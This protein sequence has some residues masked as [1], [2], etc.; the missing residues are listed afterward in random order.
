MFIYTIERNDV[1]GIFNATSPNPVIHA[2]FMRE[3]RHALRRPW[4]PPVPKRVRPLASWLMQE[5]PS[6]ALTS[7]RAIPKHFLD[8]GFK[9]EFPELQRAL[10]NIYSN[11]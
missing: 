6:L 4:R 7:C 11:E 2:R 5:E 10:A 1:A 9:F 3:L 8:I